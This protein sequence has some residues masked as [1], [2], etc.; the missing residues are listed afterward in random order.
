MNYNYHTHTHLCSHASGTMEEYVLRAIDCGITHMGFSDHIPY[1]CA[2]GKET[3]YRIPTAKT[4]DYFNEINDLKKKYGDK[5]DIKIGFE[6]EYYH[7]YFKK[8]FDFAKKSG[9]EYLILGEHHIDDESIST[10]HT[11][12]L[13]DSQERLSAYANLVVEA[14]ETE[15]FT[16]I[17]HPDV[18][19]FAG[20]NDFYKNQMRKICVASKKH[21]IPLEINLLGIRENRTYPKEI[22]WQIAGE[23]QCPVTFGF[24]AHDVLSAYDADSII[25]AKEWVKKFNLNYIGKPEIINIQKLQ[26]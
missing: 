20:D 11:M 12:A 1:V 5:I 23:E 8:M 9:P 24:D 18:F 4:Q 16:Y 17:A 2:N 7:D 22:F 15:V 6:M 14:I 13:S 3:G 10:Q 19:Y 26:F 21:N 25:I